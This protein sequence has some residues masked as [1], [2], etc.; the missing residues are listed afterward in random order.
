MI[1]EHTKSVDK[2]LSILG[3]FTPASPALR[4]KE[5]VSAT[6]LSQSTVSRLL[7]TMLDMGYVIRDNQSGAYSL[8]LKAVALAGVA[9]GSNEIY[10]AA[11]PHI[12]ELQEKS[13]YNTSLGVLQGHEV[14]F[15]A[16]VGH[17]Y[18]YEL[19]TP[20]GSSRPLHCTAIGK[21]LLAYLGENQ[22]RRILP[23]DQLQKY[24]AS[25]IINR[26]Q[27]ISELNRIR[28]RGWAADNAE[29]IPDKYCLAAPLFDRSGKCCAA[30]SIS[31]GRK[32]RAALAGEEKTLAVLLGTASRISSALGYFVK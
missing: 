22:T 11:Y 20:I 15:L 29:M 18:L 14:F 19:N 9:L 32:D 13:G 26:E 5:L 27:L 21:V 6:G 8:G 1:A 25:T 28:F 10:R 16:S 31:G 17:Q 7:S 4:V 23:G 12:C 24:T 3:C 30:I 2:A